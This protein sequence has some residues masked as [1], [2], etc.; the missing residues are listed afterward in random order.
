MRR[1]TAV[2]LAVAG[3]ATPSMAASHLWIFSEVFSN[4][5]GSI[6]F[7]EMVECCGANNETFLINK[8]VRSLGTGH[9][10]TFP[11]NLPCTNCTAHKHLLL[12]TASYASLA[13]A[14]A[15]DY[16]IPTGSLP[17]F[18]IGGDTLEYWFYPDATWSFGPVPTDGFNSLYHD[19]TVA[20]NSPTNFAGQSGSVV[21]NCNPADL[22]GDGSV[23]V[24]DM[25]E[26]L[27]AWGS[28][29]GRCPPDLDGNGVVA[30]GDFLQLLGSWGPC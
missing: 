2:S 27:S 10:F 30:V 22:D 19:G 26:L 23:G 4:P 16:I 6:Q 20:C 3:L 11:T 8:W 21:A 13:G 9:Q 25:L 28:D 14:P 1:L 12:A 18:A 17:F 15:P 29:T 5:S 7:I 24:T